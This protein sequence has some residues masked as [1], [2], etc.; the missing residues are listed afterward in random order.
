MN[1]D[2]IAGLPGGCIMRPAAGQV[3]STVLHSQDEANRAV[4]RVGWVTIHKAPKEA[5]MSTTK[6]TT[7]LTLSCGH[8]KPVEGDEI[9]AVG[10]KVH[11][12][13]CPG[14][15]TGE[16]ATRTVK[17][18]GGPG[19][20]LATHEQNVARDVERSSSPAQNGHG[21]PD[22]EHVEMA[23]IEA[24]EADAEVITFGSRAERMAA[25]R[26]AAAEAA[27]AGGDKAAASEKI[28]AMPIKQAPVEDRS[29]TAPRQRTGRLA[30]LNLSVPRN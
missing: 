8:V 13:K 14:R 17:T 29:S 21:R 3:R 25:A 7:K 4:E 6:N 22:P 23:K 1:A 11:C 2:E 30:F 12:A 20:P 27:A 18:I 19:Q 16:M 28:L 10:D 9:P 24:D 15:S 5:P 26:D